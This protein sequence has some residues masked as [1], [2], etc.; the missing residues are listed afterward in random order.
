MN[1][2]G[3]GYSLTAPDTKGQTQVIVDAFQDAGDVP[4]ETISYIEA[5]GTATRNHSQFLVN[6]SADGSIPSL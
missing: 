3:R 1:H 6:F 2:N 4:A 5:H